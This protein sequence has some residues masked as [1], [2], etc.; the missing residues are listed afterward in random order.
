MTIEIKK[1]EK[2]RSKE[3]GRGKKAANKGR[4]NGKE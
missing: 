2:E 4:R 3:R 1:K